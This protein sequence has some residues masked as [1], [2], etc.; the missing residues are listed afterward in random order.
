MPPLFLKEKDKKEIREN[1]QISTSSMLNKT[2]Y[3]KHNFKTRNAMRCNNHNDLLH[4]GFVLKIW[5]FSEASLKPSRSSMM[6]I[7]RK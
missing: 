6:A 5:L 7:F 4:L 2:F 3:F 1:V